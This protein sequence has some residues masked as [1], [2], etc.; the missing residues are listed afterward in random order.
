[1]HHHAQP[2]AGFSRLNQTVG[3][4]AMQTAFQTMKYDQPGFVFRLLRFFAPRQIHEIAVG[5]IQ[6]LPDRGELQ[7]SAQYSRQ[8]RL[9]MGITCA[10]HWP[11]MARRLIAVSQFCRCNF[12]HSSVSV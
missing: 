3:V 1:M 8:H 5:G 7:P 6:S 10:S 2:A 11:E 9:Q 12:S 4:R